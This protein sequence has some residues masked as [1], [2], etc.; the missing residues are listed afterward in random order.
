M[1]D[2]IIDLGHGAGGLKMHELIGEVFG[3]SFASNIG[4][5]PD[6]SAVVETGGVRLAFTTD[7]FVVRPLFFPGGDIGRL[8]VAGTVNDLAMAGAAPRWISVSMIIEEGLDRSVL[9]RVS[10]SLG[11]TAEEAGVE[12]VTGDTKVVERGSADGLFITTSGVGIVPA[13]VECSGS[14]VLPGMVV[15]VSGTLG[16]HEA[17]IINAREGL[18]EADDLRSD[19]APLFGLVKVMLDACPDLACMRDPT[20]GGLATTLNELALQSGTTIEVDEDAVPVR[21]SVAGFCDLLGLEP[22]YLGNEGKLVA[23][24][25]DPHADRVLAAMRSHPLGADSAAIGR[26]ADG[27]ASVVLTTSLGGKRVL[28]MLSGRPIPRIC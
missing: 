10:E 27:P 7:G 23:V 28:P 20:R 24:V 14:R 18:V 25:E 22:L 1:K 8:A 2:R 21:P 11:R 9:E 13:G 5:G 4:T 6:D 12:V 17:A 19:C 26:V 16:D 15:L 3:K